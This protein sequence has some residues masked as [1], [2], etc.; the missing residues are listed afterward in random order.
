LPRQAVSLGGVESLVV[1]AAAMWRGTMNDEQM[2]VCG[3]APNG[4]RLSVG[5]E[6]VHDLQADLAQALAAT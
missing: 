1:H 3:I 4:V 2:Q 5:I 6:G